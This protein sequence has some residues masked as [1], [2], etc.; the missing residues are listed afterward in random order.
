MCVCVCVY[1]QKLFAQSTGAIE[2]TDS[3]RIPKRVSRI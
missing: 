1:L 3:I 2:Y